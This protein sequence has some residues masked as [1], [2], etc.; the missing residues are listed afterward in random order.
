MKYFNT[1]E[2]MESWV[3]FLFVVGGRGTGK[4]YNT[5]SELHTRSNS[6]SKYVFIRRTKDEIKTMCKSAESD[7]NMNL[8]P[9]KEHNARY[10]WS[11]V[12]EQ[13]SSDVFAFYDNDRE[14]HEAYIMPLSTI[15][16]VKG[17]SYYDVDY[18]FFDE[19]IPLPG[20]RDTKNDGNNFIQLYETIARNREF[21]GREPLKAIFCANASTV[22]NSVFLAFDLINEV[23]EMKLNHIS[24][25]DLVDRGI[26]VILLDDTGEFTERKKTTALYRALKPTSLAYK[27]AIDNDF[28]TDD[29][30]NVGYIDM[31]AYKPRFR[32]KD[33][34]GIYTVLQ[35]GSLWAITDKTV[36][37]RR[38][39]KLPLYDLT[40]KEEW[41]RLTWDYNEVWLAHCEGRVKYATMYL[42]VL[43]YAMY[44]KKWE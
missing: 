4:S 18:I 14:L 32:V 12:P 8:S 22:A 5:L 2:H 35:N 31:G 39:E 16:K 11:I 41:R 19:F 6:N 34:N 29:Y 1:F 24:Q 17:A 27:S 13:I 33:R 9:F 37:N 44:N 30:S 43:I 3:N 40:L 38:I 23:S 21:D 20:Q 42:K 28:I 10:G 36:T 7:N 15:G 26:R 25:L